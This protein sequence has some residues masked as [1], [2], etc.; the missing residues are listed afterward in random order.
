MPTSTSRCEA[1]ERLR[2]IAERIA[3]CTRCRLHESRTNPVPGE[4]NPCTGVVFVGEAPGRNEDIQGRPF[5]GAA[6]KLLN[7]LLEERG[8]RR[9]DVY[10]TNIVKC[11]PPGNRD[12]KDD[13][14]AACIPYLDEQ[15]MAIRPRLVVMLGRHSTRHLLRRYLGV[16]AEGIMSVRGRVYR[17]RAPWGEAVFFPTLH[18]AAALYNP[19]LRAVL[20]RD[21]DEIARL[22]REARGER[23]G[24]TL[25]DFL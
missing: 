6:G 20:E 24:H 17:G 4:G 18:P 2:E 7:T 8:L 16:K 22:Y 5:V 19:R 10:I 11:R 25:D 23:R 21:F 13:E 12:P 3:V 9:E 15:L 1:E 14:V